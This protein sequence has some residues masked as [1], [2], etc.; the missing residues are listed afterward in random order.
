MLYDTYLPFYWEQRMNRDSDHRHLSSRRVKS[1][2]QYFHTERPGP[3]EQPLIFPGTNDRRAVQRQSLCRPG[4]TPSL[5]K[6]S[7]TINVNTMFN[8]PLQAGDRVEVEFSPFM[9]T[10]TNG[11]LNYYGGAILY[12]AGQGIVPWQEGGPTND[13]GSVQC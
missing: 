6:W 11:Q 7:S 1:Y 5:T 9:L 4:W 10:V 12:V 8:R 2:I 13:P 3:P